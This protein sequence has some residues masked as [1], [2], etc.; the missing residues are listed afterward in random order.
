MNTTNRYILYAISIAAIFNSCIAP[1]NIYNSAK[2]TPKG[3]FVAGIDY[4]GNIS[5]Q[6]TSL[7]SDI[8]SENV[9]DLANQ[10]TIRMDNNFLMINRAAIAYAIDPINVGTDFYFR[11]GIMKHLDA[12]IRIAGNAKAF[13]VQYQF[14]GPVGNIDDNTDEKFY[15]SVGMQFSWQKQELPSVLSDLQERLG[16]T[17]K[18]K[19]L[20]IPV[21]FSTS[22]GPEEKY[23]SFSFGVVFNYSKIKY[24]A[25]PLDIYSLNNIEITGIEKSEGYCSLGG[26][27]NVKIGYKYVYLVP[28]L[29]VY[30]QN[31]GDYQLLDGSISKFKGWT[32]IPSIGLRVRIGKNKVNI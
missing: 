19:D 28:S 32:I 3:N 11:Y 12:G 1:R 6:T 5:T 4:T 23:G 2:V 20:L 27:V 22:F 30:R 14:L 26:F 9:R 8:L 29:S 10:D 21:L 18:R 24:S 13:D 7:L 16:Y 17:F 31:Y 15:G 25:L